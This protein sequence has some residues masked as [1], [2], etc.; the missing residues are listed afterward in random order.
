MSHTCAA[1]QVFITYLVFGSLALV[2]GLLVLLLPETSGADMPETIEVSL[3]DVVA[4]MVDIPSF[5]A[6]STAKVSCRVDHN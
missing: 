6:C 3:Q 2:A 4:S 1:L 5:R